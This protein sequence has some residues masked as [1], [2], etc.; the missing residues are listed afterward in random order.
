MYIICFCFYKGIRYG[1]NNLSL[2]ILTCNIHAVINF[3]VFT[4]GATCPKIYTLNNYPYIL[5]VTVFLCRHVFTGGA[6]V[7]LPL[8]V[9]NIERGLMMAN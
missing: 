8:H 5:F 7:E 6:P 4:G 9:H 3:V 1:V 2:T